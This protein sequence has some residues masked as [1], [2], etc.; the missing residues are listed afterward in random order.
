MSRIQANSCFVGPMVFTHS[1]AFLEFSLNGNIVR[2]TSHFKPGHLTLAQTLE[3][4]KMGQALNS[5]ECLDESLSNLIPNT[6][7]NP[8]P[9]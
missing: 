9:F 8:K 4:L 1:S 2:L 7:G 5:F 3:S 6:A